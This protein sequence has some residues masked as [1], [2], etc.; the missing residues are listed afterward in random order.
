MLVLSACEITSSHAVPQTSEALMHEPFL[1]LISFLVLVIL[2]SIFTLDPTP[3]RAH[4][5]SLPL[6]AAH[7]R[8]LPLTAAHCRS[9]PLTAAHCCQFPLTPAHSRSLPHR[10]MHKYL[11]ENDKSQP[12]Y[13]TTYAPGDIYCESCRIVMKTNGYSSGTLSYRKIKMTE[14]ERAKQHLDE[15]SEVKSRSRNNSVSDILQ[16]VSCVLPTK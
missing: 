5:R 4:C 13:C 11:Q 2:L 1:L 8:S 3:I 6:A 9:L 10:L 14:Y 7:C 12:F 16:P 15:V